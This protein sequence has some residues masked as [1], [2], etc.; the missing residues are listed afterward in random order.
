MTDRRQ[1]QKEQRAAKKEL[2]KK[3]DAR[4][5]L[6]KR[7]LTALGFGI[8]VVAV[9]AIAS[10]LSPD[11]EVPSGYEAFRSQPTACGA[12]QPPEEP[13]LQFD[14][15]EV[16]TDIAGA[17]SATAT[18]ETS[19]GPIE[20]GLNLDSLQTVNSFAFL[21]REGFYDGQVF[22]RILEGFDAQG[23]DPEADGTGGP[24]YRVP[25]EFPPDDFVYDKG[26]VFMANRGRGTTGSQ[27][28]IALVDLPSLN[29]NF[30][31]LGQVVS[32]Q[33]TLEKIAMVDTA[34]SPG[35]RENSLPLESVYINSVTIDIT[36]S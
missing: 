13:V 31:L 7:L 20:I 12:D 23:G 30:N 17:T 3:R 2:E 24:G 11:G 25:D 22:H 34:L 16:Q 35:T 29:P 15:P 21:A 14:E 26:A 5:E 18:I 27:F 19:C 10:F 9:F 1:R 32:G 33:E 6:R 8:A 28:R 36:G 4:K